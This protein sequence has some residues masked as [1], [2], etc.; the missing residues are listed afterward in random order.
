MTRT[1]EIPTAR[2]LSRPPTCLPFAPDASR[3]LFVGI[4]TFE[5]EEIAPL[6]FAVDDAIDLAFLFSCELGLVAPGR[7]HLALAGEPQKSDTADELA[8]LLANRAQ[9]HE[10]RA[11]SLKRLVFNLG[12]EIGQEGLWALTFSTHGFN[13]EGE[14]VIASSDCWSARPAST[15]VSVPALLSDVAG[16]TSPRR[17]L[18]LDTCRSRVRRGA[19]GNDGT[20]MTAS[21]YAAIA[22]TS[23]LCVLSS[24]TLGGVSYED[25]SAGNGVFTGAVVRG[26]REGVAGDGKGF[27]TANSLALYVNQAVIRWV[28]DK[29]SISAGPNIGITSQMEGI[30]GALPLAATGEGDVTARRDRR[31]VE[32]AQVHLESSI[33]AVITAHDCS[34]VAR[35][36]SESAAL[37][38]EMRGLLEAAIAMPPTE[39]AQRA[40][41][42]L[43]EQLRQSDPHLLFRSGLDLL[44]GLSGQVDQRA[45]QRNFIAAAR[46]GKPVYRVWVVF[47]RRFG[48]CLFDRDPAAVGSLDQHD[49][50]A[51]AGDVQKG[52][53]DSVLA[54][55]CALRDG[56]GCP[57]DH[58]GA[59]ALLKRGSDANDPVALNAFGF[60]LELKADFR[61]A[62]EAYRTAADLGHVGAMTN[63]AICY[64]NGRG[65]SA[66][67]AAALEWLE[68]AADRGSPVAMN[69]LGTVYE[70]GKGVPVDLD[71][72]GAWY[73][74]GA[75]L[76]DTD[77]MCG[78]A[79]LRKKWK[80]SKLD[81]GAATALYKQAAAKGNTFALR[82]LGAIRADAKD[83]AGALLI[84]RQAAD[85][86]D[87]DAMTII[88]VV[89]DEGC[90]V[91]AD[92]A[93]AAS[94]YQK[95]VDLDSGEAAYKLAQLYAH[96]RGVPK[97][98]RQSTR[99]AQ[100]AGELGYV[101]PR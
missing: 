52:D 100:R 36:A 47:L 48:L 4:N 82:M 56:L 72:A 20:G 3:G 40:F 73:S 62:V 18:L 44:Y 63:L 66:N 10:T 24:A 69:Q 16:A 79:G 89:Y 87:R 91:K 51:L 84:W 30:G 19:R 67:V 41:V 22:E 76:G 98:P 96:G 38:P 92:P 32:L 90:D 43:H 7:V 9:R 78:L 31:L 88:G 60:L 68:K 8:W 23:G 85:L 34:E 81:E 94:W 12:K 33:G 14:D 80:G 1:S 64:Q 21:L 37:S 50:A 26:L 83:M 13:L 86:G 93:L 25:P 53:R 42:R 57:V 5:D 54:L 55:G 70:F 97:D 71:S 99:L 29:E 61:G 46:G 27:V 11:T 17:L 77:A 74:R 2:D 101:P 35:L 39:E 58:E 28:R 75:Q 59:A 45:A 6:R 49:F 65:L 95:A 15:G